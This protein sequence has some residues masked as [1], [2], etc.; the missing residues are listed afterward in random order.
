[1][2]DFPNM[3]P[4]I[5]RDGAETRSPGGEQQLQELGAVLHAQHD[6]VAGFETTCR[7]TACETRDA[8]DEFPITPGVKTVANRRRLRLSAGDIEQQRGEVHGDFLLAMINNT[9]S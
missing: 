9:S 4:G 6:T 1:M 7:E 5:Y 3:Q 8:A 2:L